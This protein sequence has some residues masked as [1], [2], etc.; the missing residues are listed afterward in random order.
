MGIVVGNSR[1]VPVVSERTLK[2]SAVELEALE[3]VICRKVL[4]EA[5]RDQNARFIRVR[6]GIG[7]EHVLGVVSEEVRAGRKANAAGE[8]IPSIAWEEP[9]GWEHPS[10]FF[11][12][13]ARGNV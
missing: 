2:I 4:T 7:E 5:M 8:D 6:R 10:G 9:V 12:E 3:C 1:R 11:Y 13:I